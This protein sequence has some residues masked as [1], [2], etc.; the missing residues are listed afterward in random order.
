MNNFLLLHWH[1]ILYIICMTVPFV[2]VA[3]N[4]SD[5]IVTKKDSVF[6]CNF[7]SSTKHVDSTKRDVILL[8]ATG[9]APGLELCIKSLRST[10]SECRIILLCPSKTSFSKYEERIFRALRVEVVKYQDSKYRND[11]PHMIRYDFEF[12]WLTKH[13]SEVDRVFHTDSF[14]VFFQGDPFSKISNVT[15]KELTFV[16]EP[17]LIRSC[18]WNTNWLSKCYVEPVLHNMRQEYIICSGSI[19]GSSKMYLSLLD[20]MIHSAEWTRCWDRSLDQPIL[21]FAVWNGNVSRQG[22]KYKLTGCDNGFF[23]VTWCVLEENVRHNEHG[24]IISLSGSVP[25]YIHQY[26]RIDSFTNEL[27][28]KCKVANHKGSRR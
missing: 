25:N 3:S 8:Y 9:Y 22:I 21:N 23:T 2:I 1:Y 14:D 13:I 10:G 17:H 12:K 16:V 28:R 15:D 27:Y 19:A 24:Q 11:V 26:N 7:N 18:G 4:R 5:N 20:M 6:L